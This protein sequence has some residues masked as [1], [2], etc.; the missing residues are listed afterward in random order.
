MALSFPLSGTEFWGGLPVVSA[1]FHLGEALQSSRTAGGAILTASLGERLW[2]C[3]I[4]LEARSHAAAAK[5]AARLSILREPGRSIYAWPLEKP[6]PA[7]D[8]DGAILGASA[9]TIYTLPAGNRELRLQG[10]PPGY[11]ISDGDFLS[12]VQAGSP[13]L[14]Q[15]VVGGTASGA[16]F[17]PPLEVTPNLRPGAAVGLAVQL[18]R[19][20]C[21]MVYVP[22]SHRPGSAAR[23]LTSGLS[24]SF[25]QTLRA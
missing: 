6:Y 15:V 11:V 9:V 2:S 5:A 3:E 19:P 8:P 14:H 22:D 4:Q 24:A 18:I 23:A 13:A 12:F 1:T 25:L 17:T 7:A 16:G 21:R 20:F 10:L